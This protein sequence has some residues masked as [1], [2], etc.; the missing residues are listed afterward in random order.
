MLTRVLNLTPDQQ[1]GVKAVLDQR[2]TQMMALRNKAESQGANSDAPETRQA[3]MTQMDQIRE[4]SNTKIADLLDDNQK[5]TFT[6]WVQERKAEMARRRSHEGNP[7]PSNDS[8]AA[9]NE[10]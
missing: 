9:P 2:N 5:K 10:N 1:T 3:R 4:E 7:P 8:G 6:D